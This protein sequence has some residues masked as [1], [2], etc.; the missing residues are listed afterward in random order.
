MIVEILNEDGTMARRPDLEGFAREHGLKIGTIADLIH[1]RTLHEK[2][3]ERVGECDLPTQYGGLRLI[4]YQDTIDNAVHYALIKGKLNP[5]EPI[6]V[7]VHLQDS[8]CDLTGSRR[9]DCGWPLGAAL[10]RIAEQESGVVV[11]L[12]QR[13]EA[14]EL[15]RRIQDYQARDDGEDLPSREKV[16]DL[17]TYG[18]GAQILSDL[19]V[20]RMR[21]MSAPRKMHAISGFGLEVTEYISQ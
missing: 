6:L 16:A 19:G 18:L 21:V 4:A 9:S 7:R 13:E 11:I 20:R 14:K 1:Y 2:T 15:L 3:V 8:L 12:R 5:D 10:Q 17:R